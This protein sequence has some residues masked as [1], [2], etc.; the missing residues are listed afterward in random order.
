LDHE[1]R[2][3]QLEQ[4][5]ADQAMEIARLQQQLSSQERSLGRYEETHRFVSARRQMSW[6]PIIVMAL[7]AAYLLSLKK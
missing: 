4:R 5:V 3:A 2:L 6:F 7:I 1:T